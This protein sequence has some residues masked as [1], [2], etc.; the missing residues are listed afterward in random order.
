[1]L[2]SRFCLKGILFFF[3][4]SLFLFFF[5]LFFLE[6]EQLLKD[7][8]CPL[9]VRSTHVLDLD[10]PEERVAFWFSGNQFPPF[11]GDLSL[12]FFTDNFKIQL[13]RSGSKY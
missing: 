11:L 12:S 4:F 13:K 6:C 1:M 10:H 3:R 2:P 9:A 7:I 8:V 5:S